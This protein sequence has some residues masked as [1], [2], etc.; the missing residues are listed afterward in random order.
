MVCRQSFTCYASEINQNA[1]VSR[2]NI[3]QGR[4]HK[5]DEEHQTKPNQDRGAG[6]RRGI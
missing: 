2:W 3:G 1:D 5:D 4:P 6:N